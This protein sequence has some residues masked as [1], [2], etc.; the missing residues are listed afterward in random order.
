[1][2]EIEFDFNGIILNLIEQKNLL[3]LGIVDYSLIKV[4]ISKFNQK[5]SKLM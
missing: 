4:N 5:L 1:V 3:E 2:D